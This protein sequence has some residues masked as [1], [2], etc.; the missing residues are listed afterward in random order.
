MREIVFDTETTG[1]N[2][3][4]GHRVI[5]IGAIELVNRMPTG[6]TFHQYVNPERDVPEEAVRIHGLTLD[7]LQDKPLFTE[8]AED[9]LAFIGEEADLVAHNAEFDMAFV[10]WELEN[11]GRDPIPMS[12]VVDT[13]QIARS[14]FPGAQASL[15]ALCKRFGIDNSRRTLHGALLD[16]EILADVYLELTGGRQTGL[17]L[18]VETRKAVHGDQ[19]VSFPRR[20]FPPAEKEKEAHARFIARMKAPLWNA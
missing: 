20:E 2:P 19:K 1:L 3:R 16:S 7:V 13:L 15:D 4:Q 8:I 17:E 14:K 11:I 5:E 12:R 9:F 6:K 18:T 10:N